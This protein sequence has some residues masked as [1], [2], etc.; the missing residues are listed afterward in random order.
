MNYLKFSLALT[1]L[2]IFSACKKEPVSQSGVGGQG[3]NFN[4]IYDHYNGNFYGVQTLDAQSFDSN[5]ERDIV[6]KSEVN[7]LDLIFRENSYFLSDTLQTTFSLQP[8]YPISSTLN[9]STDFNQ[10]TFSQTYN[11]DVT[12]QDETFSG[13]RTS[14]LVTNDSLH[15]LK[16]Q[17][18]GT[19]IL[20]VSKYESSNGLSV[21]QIDTLDVSM[22][23]YNILISSN[24]YSASPFYSFYRG[25]W[26]WADVEYEKEVYWVEDSIYLNYKTINSQSATIDTV[27]HIYQGTRL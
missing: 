21:N 20:N 5:I 27:H 7:G 23:G 22:S 17:L 3:P 4:G 1:L 13:Q 2:L 19:F 18:E 14:M 11:A 9:F 8:F 12:Y 10:I 6:L 15:P 16:N 26:T 25:H 24:S